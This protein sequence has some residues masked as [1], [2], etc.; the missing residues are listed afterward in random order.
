MDKV[1]LNQFIK[2]CVKRF[3]RDNHSINPGKVTLLIDTRKKFVQIGQR[4]FVEEHE[5]II[6]E[7]LFLEVEE[8]EREPD[9]T[10]FENYRI[11]RCSNGRRYK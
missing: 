3:E 2:E 6:Q 7:P 9:R 1:D 5:S 4:V 10:L 8:W 11:V